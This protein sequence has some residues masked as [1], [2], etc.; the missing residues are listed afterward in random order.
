LDASDAAR[1][2]IPLQFIVKDIKSLIVKFAH[3]SKIARA[4]ETAWNEH[5]TG[6]RACRPL[7]P[8]YDVPTRWSSTYYLLL[9]FACM[10]PVLKRMRSDDL[11]LEES[12][13]LALRERLV[14]HA[15]HLPAL[16]RMLEHIFKWT[17]R[18]SAVEPSS[19]LVRPAVLVSDKSGWCWCCDAFFL[20]FFSTTVLPPLIPPS[21]I[22][23][24]ASA[25][26]AAP[27]RRA[28]QEA[29]RPSHCAGGH[30][31]EP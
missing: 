9:R 23:A 29:G 24:G 28:R 10:W 3:S 21:R 31:Q 11:D 22:P 7:K 20:A 16:L 8:I 30:S 17:E 4:Y 2:C 14:G 5:Y 13:W 12:E 1:G 19:F 27:A 15:Q 6:A 25:R 26:D 18:F